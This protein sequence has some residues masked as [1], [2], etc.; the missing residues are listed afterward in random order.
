MSQ[1]TE[2]S[3]VLRNSLK[4]RLKLVE[5]GFEEQ[6]WGYEGETFKEYLKEFRGGT[7]LSVTY[8]TV[9]LD[10]RTIEIDGNLIHITDTQLFE[11]INILDNQVC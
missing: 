5:L 2:N 3:E 10:V 11:L 9:A 8:N 7:Y 1:T 6:E 4:T